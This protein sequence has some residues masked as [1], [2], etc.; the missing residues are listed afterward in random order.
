MLALPHGAAATG[1][2]ALFAAGLDERM[3]GQE[4]RQVRGD[5]DRPHARAAAAVRDAEGLVQVQVADVGAVVARPAQA[6][7]GVHVR[8]V[9]IDLAAVG[10]HDV[11]DLAHRLLEDAVRR[12]VGDHQ[13]GQGV[14]V[15]RGL[16]LEIGRGRCCPASSQ[17]TGTT[18]IPA[19]TAL[20]GLVPWAETGIRQTSR[21]VSP[22]SWW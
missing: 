4:G 10:V 2:M 19:I 21:C 8:A 14:G 15:L 7:L 16:G 20:A 6:D 13:R 3:A 18:R 5:R 22:R 12:R 11:A 17:A 1:P 9:E